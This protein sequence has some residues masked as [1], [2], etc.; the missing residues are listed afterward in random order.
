[1]EQAVSETESSFLLHAAAERMNQ[2]NA[3]YTTA[4]L[5]PNPS[6]SG[7]A[8][9]Q[10]FPGRPF[11]VMKTGGP[12]QYDLWTTYPLDWLVF[13]KRNAAMNTAAA[14]TQVANSE[15]QDFVRQRVI[16]TKMAFFDVLEAKELRDLAKQDNANLKQVEGIT[17]KQVDLGGAGTVELDRVRLALFNSERELGIRETAYKNSKSTLRM[18]MGRTEGSPDFDVAGSLEVTTPLEPVATD[19]VLKTAQSVRPDIEAARKQV[20]WANAALAQ[21]EV[22]AKPQLSGTVGFTYQQQTKA[23]GQPDA[24]SIGGG[25]LMTLPT[26]DKNQGNITKAQSAYSQAYYNLQARLTA[27]Q[28]EVEQAAT[29]Y[30]AAHQAVTSIN[31]GQAAA[32]KNVRDKVAAAFAAGGRPLIEVLDTERAYRETNRLLINGRASYWKSLNQL[33]AVAGT[34][35]LEP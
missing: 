10:P 2:A 1:L 18:L 4:T 31:I 33:N 5:L 3:D 35:V 24:P 17:I 19:L 9:L 8:S 25:I 15:F 28:S 23:L 30:R 21:E 27:L 11:T 22:K 14:G 29:A 7:I 6:L 12:P 16:V 20:E 32:A 13:G 34:T 26:F